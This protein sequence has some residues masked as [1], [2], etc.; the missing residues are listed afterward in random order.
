M[1]SGTEGW[2][3]TKHKLEKGLNPSYNGTWFRGGAFCNQL[4]AKGLILGFRSVLAENK[5]VGHPL[6]QATKVHLLFLYFQIYFSSFFRHFY[7]FVGFVFGSVLAAPY[8][9][10]RWCYREGKNNKINGIYLLIDHAVVV[11]Y[12]RKTRLYHKSCNWYDYF[13]LAK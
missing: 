2:E 1:V 4:I 6:F 10:L 11:F 7:G 3:T 5:K 13:I 8:A 12:W 9:R